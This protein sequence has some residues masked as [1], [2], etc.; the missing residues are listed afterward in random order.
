[1]SNK[2]IPLASALIFSASV[3]AADVPKVTTDIAPVHSLVSKVMDVSGL[4]VGVLSSKVNEFGCDIS[5]ILE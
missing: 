3:T 2:I 5:A 4:L 1:M